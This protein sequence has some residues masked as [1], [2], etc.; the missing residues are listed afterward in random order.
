MKWPNID[1]SVSLCIC[2]LT[3]ACN[4]ERLLFFF[5]YSLCVWGG[6]GFLVRALNLTVPLGSGQTISGTGRVRASF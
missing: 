4:P 1:E 6:G 2:L 5:G 3:V